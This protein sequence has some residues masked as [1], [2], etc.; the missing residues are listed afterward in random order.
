[1]PRLSNSFYAYDISN[2]KS[3][4]RAL[5]QLRKVADVYQDSVFDCR[6][7]RIEHQALQQ[8]LFSLLST[9]EQI[10]HIALPQNTLC[11]QLGTGL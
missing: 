6:L 7:S 2:S 4:R 5:T 10:L 11:L 1:M 8:S 9:G 3:R